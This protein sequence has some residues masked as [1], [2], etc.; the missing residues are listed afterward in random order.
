MQGAHGVNRV[1]GSCVKGRTCFNKEFDMPRQKASDNLPTPQPTGS[2]VAGAII[3]GAILTMATSAV[4]LG[5]GAAIQGA[6][7]N[8]GRRLPR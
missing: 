8:G 6:T 3:G 4:V 2:W 5:A 1:A 7:L